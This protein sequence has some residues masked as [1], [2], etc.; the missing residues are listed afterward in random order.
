MQEGKLKVQAQG[1]KEVPVQ[2]GLS[3]EADFPHQGIVDFTD[4]RVDLNT[5]TLRFR[6]KIDNPADAQRQPLH[7]PGPVRAGA[8]ADRRPSPRADGPRAGAG[9]RPGPQDGLRRQEKKDRQG[10]PVNNEKGEPVHIAMVR[11]VGNVGVLRDG[12]R[13]VE[14]GIEPGDWVVVAGCSGSA[15][16]RGQGR[17]IRRRAGRPAPPTADAR[18]ARPP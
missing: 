16:D 18:Q 2:I 13:E 5:G 17:E 1:E 14:K 8:A 7:R 11:D 3:D 9:D 12:F 4:N 6:A 15:R 10:K